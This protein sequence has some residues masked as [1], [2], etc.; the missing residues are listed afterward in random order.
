MSKAT[1]LNDL[2]RAYERERNVKW[3]A[4]NSPYKHMPKKRWQEVVEAYNRKQIRKCRRSV[5]KSN[6][7][8]VR[9]TA[10]GM[11]R[12]LNHLESIAATCPHVA[13]MFGGEGR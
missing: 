13:N 12:W 4:A 10:L 6:K 8:G 11:V 7:L 1:Y 5:G 9:R 2:T 3:Q